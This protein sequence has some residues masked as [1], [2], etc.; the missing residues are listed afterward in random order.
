M[1]KVGVNFMSVCIYLQLVLK[2]YM[3]RDKEK[4]KSQGHNQKCVL[5]Q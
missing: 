3:N 4:L 5:T 1:G 2:E